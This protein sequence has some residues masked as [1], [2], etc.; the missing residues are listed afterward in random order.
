MTMQTT[1]LEQMADEKPISACEYCGADVFDESEQAFHA[2]AEC[3]GGVER[4]S[5]AGE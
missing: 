5:N 1:T 3:I 2:D 4:F